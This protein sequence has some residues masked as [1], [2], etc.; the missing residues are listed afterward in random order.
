[1]WFYT[2][3]YPKKS[4]PSGARFPAVALVK[5]NWDDFGHRTSFNLYFCRSA[6]D[7]EEV[8]YVKIL[9]RENPGTKLPTEFKELPESRYC[10]L[11]QSFGYYRTFA[12]LG[13]DVAARILMPL[14]DIVVNKELAKT[15]EGSDAFEKSLLRESEAAKIWNGGSPEESFAAIADGA[16]KPP[17]RKLSR[18]RVRRFTFRCRVP[19]AVEDHVIDFEFGTAPKLPDRQNVLIGKNATGKT[20]LLRL[21]ADGLAQTS[22]EVGHFSPE[23]PRFSRVIAVSY[24]AFDE[25]RKPPRTGPG[26]YRYC[27]I[28]TE[29]GELLSAQRQVR[30]VMRAVSEI[31]KSEREAVWRRSLGTALGEES[32][33]LIAEALSGDEPPEEGI[34]SSGHRLVSTVLTQLLAAIEE[35]SL[36]L[37]DEPELH[38]HPNATSG[39]IAAIHYI[40]R[41]FKSYGVI[42][43]HSPIILQ[44]TPSRYVR[45]LERTGDVPSVQRPAVECFGENL[46]AIT[47]DVFYSRRENVEYRRILRRLAQ[48][49]SRHE[50]ERLFGRA[51]SFNAL[52]LIANAREE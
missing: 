41:E 3:S 4:P 13:S 2:V 46:T 37:F 49:L 28:Y 30:L 25:F 32:A 47:E 12:R 33:A 24:S 11:G 26:S 36:V 15:W 34:L 52:T 27:G 45:V 8:G 16:S 7:I 29:A 21:L 51:L 44:Q 9:D 35:D 38:L 10:S 14:N 43:T 31:R 20:Q 18:K 19:G 42:S 5:D 50:I 6:S 39:L 17:K 1:M 48:Q 23:R 40:L 22:S